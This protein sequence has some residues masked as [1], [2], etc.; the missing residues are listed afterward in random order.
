MKNK[1]SPAPATI[2]KIKKFPQSRVSVPLN[3][4]IALYPLPDIKLV[5]D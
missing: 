4:S 5:T 2:K 3:Q 1:P